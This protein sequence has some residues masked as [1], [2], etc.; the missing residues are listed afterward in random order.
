MACGPGGRPST[1]GAQRAS[2]PKAPKTA[3]QSRQRASASESLNAPGRGST[4]QS[5]ATSRGAGRSL[6]LSL[7]HDLDDGRRT[8]VDAARLVGG[9]Q[10]HDH[11]ALPRTTF[12]WQCKLKPRASMTPL[13]AQD[14][15]LCTGPQSPSKGTGALAAEVSV[16]DPTVRPTRRWPRCAPSSLMSTTWQG[17]SW[18]TA[19]NTSSVEALHPHRRPALRNAAI[20]RRR[21]G[22]RH[23]PSAKLAA[24]SMSTA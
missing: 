11:D 4:F 19:R 12:P 23:D 2:S 6:S 20:A 17:L 3:C 18:A 9:M 15:T 16:D 1:A 10:P 5:P 22:A 14:G 24:D 21:G 7:S 8:N 13:D